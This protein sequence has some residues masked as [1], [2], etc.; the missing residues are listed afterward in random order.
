[1]RHRNLRIV[2]LL[3]IWFASQVPAIGQSVAERPLNQRDQVR[4][5]EDG[6][7]PQE[8]PPISPATMMQVR[9]FLDDFVD[10]DKT[11][12][13]QTAFFAEQVEYY[14]RGIVGKTVILRDVER[15]VRHWPVRNYR[16]A[17][18]DY[19]RRDANS[20]RVF[21]SY[22]IE[23]DVANRSKSISGRANYGALITGLG[24]TPKIES[25]KERVTRRTSDVIRLD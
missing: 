8:G 12:E 2:F 17:E 18:I 22:T 21:V 23:F 14:E 16:V 13:Q 3:S 11:P 20:D 5:R 15:F 7:G 4:I 25:I 6:S 1:M 9:N 19:I 24:D 10:A